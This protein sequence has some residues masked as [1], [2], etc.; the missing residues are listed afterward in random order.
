[1]NVA[2]R[3]KLIIHTSLLLLIIFMAI[4]Y[5]QHISKLLPL[6]TF[7]VDQYHERAEVYRKYLVAI[8]LWLTPLS[9]AAAGFLSSINGVNQ[10]LERFIQIWSKLPRWIFFAL[11]PLLFTLW[12]AWTSYDLIGGVPR[13]FDAFNYHFQ[14]KNFALKQF[15][16][17]EPPVSEL[18]NF[19]FIIIDKGKWYGSVYPG[20][21]LLLSV[22][23]K[24][25]CDWFVNPILGGIGLMLMYFTA[26]SMFGESQARLVS[27]FGLIS[28]FYRM[29]SSIFMAHVAG[30]V[31][32]VITI[33]MLWWWSQKS[34][35]VPIFVPLLAG[36][37]MGWIYITRP[38]IGVVTLPLFLLH[39]AYRVR[40]PGRV[41]LTL[42]VVPLIASILFLAIYNEQ[43]TGDYFVNPRYYVDPERRLGFGGDLGEPLA[44]GQRGGHD[45]RR[46]IQNSLLLINLW[47]AEMFGFGSMGLIGLLTLVIAYVLLVNWKNT[48]LLL[49]GSSIIFNMILYVFYFTPS[50]N[51]GPRYFAEII[52][53][54]L[55]LFTF[56]ILDI[57]RKLLSW[58]KHQHKPTWLIYLLLILIGVMF[59][60]MLPF[61]RAHYGILPAKTDRS[62]IPEL[63][64]PAVVLIPQEIYTM[65]IYTWN[66]PNLDG[67][68]FVPLKP[69]VGIQMIQQAFPG[70]NVFCLEKEEKGADSYIL[71]KVAER[72]ETE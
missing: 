71:R 70:R 31:G 57:F 25:G 65:N 17:L 72:L 45:L 19:P 33:W 24:L 23:V 40:F 20:Y 54:T 16:A 35:N 8:F 69:E 56:G 49:W 41:K 61:H 12:A 36:C 52:P 39:T 55:L 38:Q 62:K 29:M 14:A 51:F 3:S 68:I 21:S 9:I 11:I 53:A 43:L 50:P 1:M 66:S 59:F 27:I 32:V 63:L 4:G 10:L 26:R 15:Y 13:I 58:T 34:E 42:F 5:K 46:G 47:N 64:E 30:M 37:G 28:P 44:N 7:G 67:N 2:T 22:G 6:N 18:F 48:L 60:V